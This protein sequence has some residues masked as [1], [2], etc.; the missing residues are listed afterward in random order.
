MNRE[1][2]KQITDDPLKLFVVEYSI[3]QN[4]VSRSTLSNVI[5]NNL[6]NVR[7]GHAYEYVPIGLFPP[8]EDADRF[9]EHFNH[10]LAEQA[11]FEFH[12]RDC[13]ASLM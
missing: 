1:V 10:T 5:E 13:D 7:R 11:Q 8:K 12:S 6:K 4:S 9:I 2:K 3:R